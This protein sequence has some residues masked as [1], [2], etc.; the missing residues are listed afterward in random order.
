MSFS[1]FYLRSG[2]YITRV[3]EKLEGEQKLHLSVTKWIVSILI[4]IVDTTVC[5]YT[6]NSPKFFGSSK[7]LYE[8]QTQNLK[9]HIWK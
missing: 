6:A 4:A 7:N 5:S 9:F 1:V 3:V 2:D 8:F